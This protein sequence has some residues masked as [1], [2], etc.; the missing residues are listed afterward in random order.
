MQKPEFCLAEKFRIFFDFFSEIVPELHF[1][2]KINIHGRFSSA[3]SCLFIERY[4][5]F[6]VKHFWLW[7]YPT[8]AQLAERETVEAKQLSLGHWFESGWSETFL[9]RKLAF[10]LHLNFS[11]LRKVPKVLTMAGSY[12]PMTGNWS[13][14]TGNWSQMI[15]SSPQMTES[16]SQITGSGPH[17]TGSRRLEFKIILFRV[18][19]DLGVINKGLQIEL[20]NWVNKA[21]K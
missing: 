19:E 1:P 16:S 3:Q 10:N 4:F 13:E 11:F 18:K 15:K 21:T 5:L 17:M 2:R 8:I 6:D 14:S 9:I 12:S 7:W 20:Y